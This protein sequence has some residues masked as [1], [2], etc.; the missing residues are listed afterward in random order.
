M[1]SN[2]LLLKMIHRRSCR[3]FSNSPVDIQI[4]QDCIM[5]ASS[6]PNGANKQPWHF[7]VI[8]NPEIKKKLRIKCEEI[9]KEF[10]E[11]KIT[12]QWSNDLK[13]L[14]VNYQ[15][16]FLEEAPY[17]IIIFKQMS[18]DNKPNYYVNE[19]CGI[20]IGMLIQSLHLCGIDTLTYT[21]APM[22]FLRDMFQRPTSEIPVIILAAGK[23]SDTYKA[24]K[25]S[26]KNFNDIAKIY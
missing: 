25:L 12:Q 15:K 24:P 19:S 7:I 6:A 14:N 20:S 1:K 4:I 2:E 10:Y 8:Q 17:L 16:P 13:K 22:M 26:K 5:C 11:K 9:E 18:Y 21:P 3:Q 23:K